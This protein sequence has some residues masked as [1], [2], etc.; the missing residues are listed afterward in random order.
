MS[1]GWIPTSGVIQKL[2]AHVARL[3]QAR[4]LFSD[5][6][7]DGRFTTRFSVGPCFNFGRNIK[8]AK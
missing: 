8:S 2:P 1:A 7:K 6:L 3:V 4:D 5:L